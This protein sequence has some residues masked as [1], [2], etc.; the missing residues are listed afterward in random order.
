MATRATKAKGLRGIHVLAWLLG[1]FAVMVAVNTV[2]VISAVRSFPGE[3]V[4]NS[5]VLGLDYN[6]EVERKRAQDKLG[7]TSE[8]GLVHADGPRIVVRMQ[9][10]EQ[11]PVTGLALSASLHVAGQAGAVAV[12]LAEGAPGEYAAAVDAP[13]GARVELNI[14]AR[15]A[16]EDTA[17]FKASKTLAAP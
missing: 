4:K 8:A 11:R 12:D 2:F 13:A 9:D 15:R 17:V 5:Y 10:A 7:W 3:Q 16:G 6:R 14:S 1:M